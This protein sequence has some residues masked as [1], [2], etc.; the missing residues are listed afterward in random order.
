MQRIHHLAANG[1]QFNLLEIGPPAVRACAWQSAQQ[2]FIVT[3]VSATIKT[4]LRL[5]LA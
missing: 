1:G 4:E 5:E 3:L 2:E